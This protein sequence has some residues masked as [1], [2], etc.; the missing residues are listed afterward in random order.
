MISFI[1]GTSSKTYMTTGIANNDRTKEEIT[2]DKSRGGKE[3][4]KVGGMNSSLYMTTNITKGGRSKDDVTA[5]KSK[6]G[7]EGGK[8][9]S[10]YMTT[11]ITKGG[12]SKD[13]VTAEK[14]DGGAASLG[15]AKTKAN[16][17][18]N[19]WMKL[20]LISHPSGETFTTRASQ[21]KSNLGMLLGLFRKTPN[22]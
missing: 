18:K 11:N 5:D 3:G 12:R 14:R 6:G 15:V 8:N 17:S 20:E 7:K 2:T 1:G 9:S 22:G 4:G 19:D 13:D 21:T 16:G 10:Q